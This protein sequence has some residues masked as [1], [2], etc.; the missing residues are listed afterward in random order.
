MKL[1]FDGIH[2][3]KCY[4]SKSS[5]NSLT[6]WG[7]YFVDVPSDLRLSN[8]SLEELQKLNFD[9]AYI[10]YYRDVWGEVV[11]RGCQDLLF[12]FYCCYGD[13]IYFSDDYYEL[14]RKY[15]CLTWNLNAVSDYFEDSWNNIAKYDRTPLKEIHKLDTWSYMFLDMNGSEYRIGCWKNLQRENQ[16]TI[17]GMEAF[18]KAFFEVMDYYLLKIH[19]RHREVA[20][21][22]SG[23][24]DANL[25]AARWSMLFP[26]EKTDFFTSKVDDITDESQL[27]SSMQKVI[28][29]PI[30]YIPIKMESEKDLISLLKEYIERYLPP[31]FF[32]EI[33]ERQFIMSLWKNN[34]RGAHLNGMG[35]DGQFGDFGGEYLALMYEKLCKFKFIQALNIYKAI[36]I[37]FQGGGIVLRIISIPA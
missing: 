34:I 3:K 30:H 25:I 35:A 22:V 12:T 21:P 20:I 33:N 32:N 18:K 1:N 37:S 26:N 4:E 31:R 9:G 13:T 24:I 10:A 16:Y 23:G 14:A 7:D 8:C 6:I 36:T 11:F 2:L 17:H 15:D 28:T 19:D 27:A 29:S 5:D